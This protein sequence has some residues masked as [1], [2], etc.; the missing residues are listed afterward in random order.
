M[1]AITPSPTGIAREDAA[2]GIDIFTEGDELYA[3]MG[4]A[5]AGA[6]ESVDL[7]TYIFTYDSVGQA[8][9]RRLEER[10]RAGVRVRL[11]VD[12]FGSLFEFPRSAEDALKAAGVEV[13]RFHLWDW[14]NPGRYNRR[15]HRKLLVVDGREA[16][17]GGYNVNEDSSYAARGEARWRDTHVR[18]RSDLARQAQVL[19]DIFW[20]S[21][22]KRSLHYP[23]GA[24]QFL[25]SNHNRH[26]RLR[27]ARVFDLMLGSARKTL[28]LTTPYFVP[29]QRVQRRLIS[30]ARRGVD[31]RVLVPGKNDVRLARWASHAA[32][33]QLLAGGV[34]IFEYL[35][36]VLHSKT[37]VADGRW[38]MVGSSNLDYRSFFLNYEINLFSR[39]PRL[40]RV[41]AEQFE[42][43][44]AQSEEIFP[45]KW[46]RRHWLHY[47]LEAVGWAARRLL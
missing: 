5:I 21:D 2:G 4:E 43:D 38:G 41:L 29:N 34:R 47:P 8:L 7:E 16:Y 10:A 17:L 39:E 32:Y 33:A 24:R 28:W 37:A 31:V 1:R 15:N 30:A 26:A 45:D 3:A 44:L 35:P 20:H 11:H 46:S 9:A 14:R 6:R 27:L 13:R 22:F 18:V 42:I 36:R 23:A 19:F 40:C 25:L 12:A